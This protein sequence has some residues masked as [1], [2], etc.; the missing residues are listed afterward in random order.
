MQ[1]V[2]EK[3]NLEELKEMSKKM[4]DSLVQAVV[5]VEKSIMAVD[6]DMHVDEETLLLEHGSQQEHLWGINIYPYAIP[7]NM[8]EFDSMINIRPSFGN[9]SRGVDDIEMQKKIKAIVNTLITK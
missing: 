8:I 2:H 5:D 3:I 6:A 7:E 4:Y 1:I 9:R